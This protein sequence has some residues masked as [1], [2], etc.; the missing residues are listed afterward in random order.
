MLNI[1]EGYLNQNG[2]LGL[3]NRA[4]HATSARRKIGFPI[5]FD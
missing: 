3:E 5:I 1:K 2:D 4:K